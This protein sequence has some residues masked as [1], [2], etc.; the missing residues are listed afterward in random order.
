MYVYEKDRKES[1][2][3]G[4]MDTNSNTVTEQSNLRSTSPTSSYKLIN[5]K[6]KGKELLLQQ[7]PNF[8]HEKSNDNNNTV[9]DSRTLYRTIG[10]KHRINRKGLS[11]EDSKEKADIKING[12]VWCKDTTSSTKDGYYCQDTDGIDLQESSSYSTVSCSSFSAYNIRR[13]QSWITIYP[14]EARARL[15]DSDFP[16]RAINAC[17]NTERRDYRK[18]NDLDS[19]CGDDSEYTMCHAVDDGR[20][21]PKSIYTDCATYGGDSKER[22]AVSKHRNKILRESAINRNDI[23]KKQMGYEF[24]QQP[25]GSQRE[26][27]ARKRS[28]TCSCIVEEEEDYCKGI[29]GVEKELSENVRNIAECLE[30]MPVCRTPSRKLSESA[31]VSGTSFN[32]P[33]IDF[34][35][36]QTCKDSEERL[37]DINMRGTRFGNSKEP[38][39]VTGVCKEFVTEEPS[40]DITVCKTVFGELNELQEE[41]IVYKTTDSKDTPK[42]TISKEFPDSNFANQDDVNSSL[43]NAKDKFVEGNINSSKVN[44]LKENAENKRIV[45]LNNKGGNDILENFSRRQSTSTEQ[46]EQIKKSLNDQSKNL[47]QIPVESIKDLKPFSKNVHSTTLRAQ[48]YN[49]SNLDSNSSAKKTSKTLVN[50]QRIQ[51]LNRSMRTRSQRLNF[52]QNL[53][54]NKNNQLKENTQENSKEEEVR[55]DISK[56]VGTIKNKQKKTLLHRTLKRVIDVIR[57]DR[58]LVTNRIETGKIEA[59]KAIADGKKDDEKSEITSEIEDK[60]GD[61]EAQQKIIKKVAVPIR[62]QT[63]IANKSKL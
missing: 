30:K 55:Q 41:V 38:P 32:A 3:Q 12:N 47:H 27:V 18:N 28:S 4:H 25:L 35:K 10:Y 39:K 43:N 29:D 5:I 36:T 21:L 63:K 59:K 33:G 24:L 1:K 14:S 17:A 20:W 31:A 7:S 62:S 11:E 53:A 50:Q 56:E 37:K 54:P 9:R 15:D 52:T 26:Q 61:V 40:K 48:L 44:D 2:S 60:I 34:E 45:K 22:F 16:S 19:V 46:H 58:T 49:L 23:R 57:C 51:P 8:I 13:P 6:E 42:E